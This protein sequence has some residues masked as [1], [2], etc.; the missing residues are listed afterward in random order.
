MTLH[1]L[2]AQLLFTSIHRI[3]TDRSYSDWETYWNFC[4]SDNEQ[5]PP[6]MDIVH[7]Y[8][9]E[10]KSSKAERVLLINED[11]RLF[12][13]GFLATL[14]V[15]I[16]IIL[17]PSKAPDVLEELYASSTFLLNDK[18]PLISRDSS[19]YFE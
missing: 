18:P 16:P 6:F 10:I 12:L 11:K 14:T 5:N 3:L 2:Q 4:V 19:S 9:H 15:G 17:P 8:I 13:A 7:G 1:P